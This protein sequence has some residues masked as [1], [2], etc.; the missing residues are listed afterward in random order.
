[1]PTAAEAIEQGLVK[2]P[3]QYVDRWENRQ[4]LTMWATVAKNL[5]IPEFEMF[6]TL[7][8]KYELDPLLH[9]IWAAKGDPKNGQP[10]KLLM[11]VGRDGLLRNARRDATYRGFDGDVVYAKDVF[12]VKRSKDGR[13]VIH[14]WSLDEPRGAIVGAWAQVY[15]DG[16]HDTFVWCPAADYMPSSPKTY[17]SWNTNPHA[18]MQKCPLSLALR[19]A[20]NL[21][22]VVGEEEVGRQLEAFDTPDDGLQP[23]GAAVVEG[24]P[25]SLRERFVA[26]WDAALEVDA[27]PSTLTALMATQDQPEERVAE[28]IDELERETEIVRERQAAAAAKAAQEEADAPPEAEVVEPDPEHVEAQRKRLSDLYDERDSMDPDH[29]RA[30]EI[31]EEV[32]QVEADLLAAGGSIPGQESLLG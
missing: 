20:F 15:Q 2:L 29:P 4:L 23:T 10:G 27:A 26:V 12:K 18:M 17:S 3:E 24:V 31:D 14:E 13:E 30:A 11:M 22:G 8:A 19:L 1:M 21:S 5:S 7:A 32:A 9:E 25:E 28:F 16:K 6:L